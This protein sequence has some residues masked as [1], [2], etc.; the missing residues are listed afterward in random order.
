MKQP[1][2][3]LYPLAENNFD[4]PAIF[5]KPPMHLF[6]TI[7]SATQSRSDSAA[8]GFSSE[9][10]KFALSLKIIQLI[11]LSLKIVSN[12]PKRLLFIN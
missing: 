6:E 4:Y 1:V 3:K 10:E 7:V 5:P 12:I 9:Y 11:C 2:A 8:S